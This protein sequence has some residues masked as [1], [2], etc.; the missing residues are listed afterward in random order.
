MFVIYYHF[1]I[2]FSIR[3]HCNICTED[4]NLCDVCFEL[5]YKKYHQKEKEYE[6]IQKEK[7]QKRIEE[8]EIKQASEERIKNV[9]DWSIHNP[10]HEM[11]KLIFHSSSSQISKSDGLPTPHHDILSKEP[12]I[13]SSP[14]QSHVS[15]FTNFVQPT[16]QNRSNIPS[17]TLDSS[18]DL[19]Q[20]ERFTHVDKSQQTTG[21]LVVK[22]LAIRV[23]SGK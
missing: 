4:Y 10:Y 22:P 12:I 23:K 11:I 21:L 18:V 20:T 19:L 17:F 1:F 14:L 9:I 15:S 13:S 16:N 8:N 3:Y 5:L 7:L 2:L 6:R